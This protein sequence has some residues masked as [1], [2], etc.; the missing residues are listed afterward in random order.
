MSVPDGYDLILVND[1]FWVI[2]RRTDNP[3]Y[4]F[5][6][7]SSFA[8]RRPW[9]RPSSVTAIARVGAP[10]D[11]SGFS[12]LCQDHGISLVNADDQHLAGSELPKWY[13]AISD[14]TPKSRWFASPPSVAQIEQSIGWPV[15][16]KGAR[17]TSRHNPA[18]AI[19]RNRAEY[20][21]LAQRFQDDPILRWQ[22]C[23]VRQF[24]A[25]RPVPSKATAKIAPSFEF[26]T[27]WFH[28]QLA[29]AG[30]Y[31]SDT[32]SYSWTSRERDECLAVAKSAA[33]AVHCPFLVVDMAQTIDGQ[34]I[35]I[36]CNDG[37]ESGY[38]G[39]SPYAL[40]NSISDLQTEQD[41]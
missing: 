29:G 23:V 19:A 28:G 39:V 2:V 17:Q 11:Y 16:V 4:D 33:D 36:E 35:V 6:F 22:Q 30:P 15:F 14:S 5:S 21:Q 20:R 41:S 10:S 31:W 38:A 1:A 40:W 18:K 8:C 26:R 7:E 32:A 27:F 24:V 25:L 34:W 9:D 13:G 37:Q 3:A 12:R